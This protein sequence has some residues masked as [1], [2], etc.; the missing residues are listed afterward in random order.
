MDIEKGDFQQNFI[1]K[2]RTLHGRD[3]ADTTGREQFL[4]LALAIRE[5]TGSKWAVA[6]QPAATFHC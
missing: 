4:A 3:L 2:I 5:Y 1:E 6:G